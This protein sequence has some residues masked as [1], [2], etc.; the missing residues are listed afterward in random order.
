[1]KFHTAHRYLVLITSIGPFPG[2]CV[3][4]NASDQYSRD[5]FYPDSDYCQLLRSG[6]EIELARGESF[7]SVIHTFFRNLMVLS[8]RKGMILMCKVTVRSMALNSQHFSRPVRHH[9]G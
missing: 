2:W 5:E 7:R 6:W 9:R 4:P 8:A 1:M 3:K